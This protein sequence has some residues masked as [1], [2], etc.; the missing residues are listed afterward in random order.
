MPTLGVEEEFV[1]VDAETRRPVSSGGD[2]VDAVRGDGLPDG[3]QVERELKQEMVETGTSPTRSVDEVR[4]ELQRLRSLLAANA[5]QRGHRLLAAGLVP[6]IDWQDSR[7]TEGDRYERILQLHGRVMAKQVVAGL[8]V[9]VGVPSPTDAVAV[10][11][12]LGP[13]LP[14]LLVLSVSSPIY[15]GRDTGYASYR[16]LLWRTWMTSGLPATFTSVEEHDELLDQLLRSGSVLDRGQVYW[17]ARLSPQ[18]PTI[19]LRVADA[20][21]TLDEAVLQAILSR[22]IVTHLLA[23]ADGEIVPDKPLRPELARAMTWQAARHGLDGEL[24]RPSSGSWVPARTW[25]VDVVELLRPT[26]AELGDEDVALALLEQVLE[27]GTSA[28]RQ[29]AVLEAGGS[30]E[31]V[32]DHL[33]AETVAELDAT[34]PAPAPTTT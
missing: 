28:D 22:A 34:P 8:H 26:L 32:V 5:D 29:R 13:W 33:A 23:E 15:E 25:V 3:A 12:R 1:V 31:D 14:L 2:V 20:C 21:T 19:E 27:Q 9:H 7:V 30:I 16:T 18:Y 11:N 24:H 4:R 6:T 17:P 10:L